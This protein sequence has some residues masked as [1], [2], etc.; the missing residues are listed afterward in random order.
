MTPCTSEHAS[1][2]I[3]QMVSML[4]PV[5]A[6]TPAKPWPQALTCARRDYSSSGW[7]ELSIPVA[8]ERT[9]MNRA[10]MP[11]AMAA[12]TPI[13]I[14]ALINSTRMSTLL[15]HLVRFGRVPRSHCRWPKYIV[16]R[17][18]HRSKNLSG[19]PV[20][21]STR[22]A[23]PSGWQRSARVAWLRGALSTSHERSRAR[24]LQE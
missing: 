7:I 23:F 16:P 5:T 6:Q 19:L 3:M 21:T 13:V 4:G 20:E 22:P 10:A 8:R 2:R 18:S 15:L 9:I 12:M 24:S 14:A 17:A 11:T 1:R